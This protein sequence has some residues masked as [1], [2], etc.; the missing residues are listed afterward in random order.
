VTNDNQGTTTST[1]TNARSKRPPVW[2]RISAI[3]ALVVSLATMVVL[4]IFTARNLLYVVAVLLGGGLA[5]SALWIAATNRRFRWLASAAALLFVAGTVASV[6]GV[7]RGLEAV[8]VAMVGILAAAVL[9][10]LALRWEVD[11]ALTERWHRVAAARHGVVLMNPASGDGKAA[12][13]HLVDEAQQRGITPVL[14]RPHDDL[15]E[16]AETAVNQGADVLGMAGGD[17]SQ[18]V[19]AMVA[20]RHGV[21][22]VCVPAGTRNH[23]A[24]DLGIDRSDPVKALD[25]YGPAREARIDLAEVNGEV[26]VN[27]VSL[28]LYADFVAS[29]QYRKA[30]RRTVAKM[31]P[32][33]LGPGAAPSGLTVDGPEGLIVDAQ[34]IEVSNNPYTLCS[35]I[36]FGSRPWLDT[37]SLG[38][39]SLAIRRA[40]D[41]NRLVALEVSGHP[42]R[43]EGWRQWTA[44]R[45][46]VR[47][48]RPLAAA[49]DGEARTLEPPLAFAIRP[50]S[51]RV[52]IADGQKGA[53]PAFRQ[54]PVDAST[55]AGLLRVAR[56]R[57]SGIVVRSGTGAS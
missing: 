16:L 1:A 22:F 40:S 48:P 39:A 57:P 29:D 14:L 36:G 33:L 52:R 19:V 23:F 30:K 11:H 54:A 18:A 2:S 28:G 47:G 12:R 4:V 56:G 8:A 9:G 51:L 5:I 24:L 13:F 44:G 27:N 50:R 45:L 15:E 26:F 32:E 55:L 53:S 20:A 38:V 21:P 43:F 41:V 7:G 34:L 37:G 31:L 6:T 42:E 10:T 49:I 25:A 3:G 17:G 35:V 46:Q